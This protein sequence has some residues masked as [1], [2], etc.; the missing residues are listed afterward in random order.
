MPY[1]LQ[2]TFME[3]FDFS[4]S[5]TP[6]TA[7][8]KKGTTLT[9][10]VNVEL[11]KGLPQTVQLS[12]SGVPPNANAYLSTP[13]GQPPFTATLTLATSPNTP[14]GSYQVRVEAIS[15]NIT[16]TAYISLA[17]TEPEQPWPP[18]QILT[19]AFIF[20]VVVGVIGIFLK[21]RKR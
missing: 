21:L 5:M 11:A 20:V 4:V 15:G 2:A 6:A 10:T 18:E 16:R 17:I 13:S 12:V 7:T 9:F 14:T 1:A 3:A 8:A 19:A